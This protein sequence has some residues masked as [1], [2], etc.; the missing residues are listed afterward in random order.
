[1]F[2]L[3]FTWGCY[4]CLAQCLSFHRRTGSSRN[5]PS[6]EYIVSFNIFFSTGM[7]KLVRIN[8]QISDLA[9]H[10]ASSLKDMF[11]LVPQRIIWNE[12][13][14][15]TVLM[16]SVK[17]VSADKLSIL[18]SL[19][20]CTVTSLLTFH[21]TMGLAQLFYYLLPFKQEFGKHSSFKLGL[22]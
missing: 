16:E 2:A 17:K 18:H 8:I 12:M 13:S 11:C 21:E 5:S 4:S 19:I 15:F 1:M 6:T 10:A 22:Y 9:N 20:L 3:F 7:P 14:D